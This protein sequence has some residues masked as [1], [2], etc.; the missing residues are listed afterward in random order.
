MASFNLSGLDE[1]ADELN[2][3]SAF[4]TDAP[5][6]MLNAAADIYKKAWKSEIEKAG[7]IDTGDMLNSVG[8]DEIAHFRNGARVDVYPKGKDRKGT[9][10][11]EKAFVLHYGT[12]RIKPR[13]FVDA[14]IGSAETPALEAMESIWNRQK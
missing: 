1:I 5:A 2:R 8:A 4:A 13:R 9:R 6:Q 7:L 3:E 12:S 10:N 14:V 11:A